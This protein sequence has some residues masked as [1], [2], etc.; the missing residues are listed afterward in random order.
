MAS[1]HNNPKT[2]TERMPYNVYSC[3]K[4]SRFLLPSV[5]SLGEAQALA[6]AYAK[7]GIDALIRL[8]FQT[9]S[10]VT[11]EHFAAAFSVLGGVVTPHFDVTIPTAHW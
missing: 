3:H 9:P 7:R 6:N 4:G 1:G 5:A 2:Q 11:G 10:S 8:F